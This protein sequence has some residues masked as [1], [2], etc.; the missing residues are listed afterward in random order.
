MTGTSQAAPAASACAALI[1]GAVPG[2]TPE[3]VE[4]ALESSTTLVT[5]ATNGMSFPR[6]DCQQSLA[7][8]GCARGDCNANGSLD[9]GDAICTTL[10]LIGQ[11]PAGADCFCAGNCNCLNGVEASDPLCAALRLIDDFESAGCGS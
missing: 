6:V 1:K 7:A 4:A 8:V 10:C 5:D 2:A 3:E 9:A 11:P